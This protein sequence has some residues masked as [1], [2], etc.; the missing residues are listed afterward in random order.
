M[1]GFVFILGIVL[2]GAMFGFLF[3]KK[4]N[5]KEG[6]IQGAK[7]T[8]GCL[9]TLAIIAIGALFVLGLIASGALN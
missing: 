2:L 5:E 1:P 6:A 3:S 8:C 7:S 4:G 9:L